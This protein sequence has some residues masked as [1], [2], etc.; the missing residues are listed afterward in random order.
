MPLTSKQIQII[1]ECLR[2]AAYGP[3]FPDWEFTALFGLTRNEVADVAE[4]WPVVLKS[5]AILRIAVGNSINNLLGYPIKQ[6]D[7]WD[8]YISVNRKDLVNVFAAWRRQPTPDT[9]DGYFDRLM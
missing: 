7:Q 4:E 6:T 8:D 3:F 9:L 2:A 5:H 1:G